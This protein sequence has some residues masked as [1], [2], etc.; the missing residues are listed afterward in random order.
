MKFLAEEVGGAVAANNIKGLSVSEFSMQSSLENFNVHSKPVARDFYWNVENSE[1]AVKLSDSLTLIPSNFIPTVYNINV[2]TST[3]AL[4]DVV[5][6]FWSLESIGIQP[7]QEK[8]APVTL[9]S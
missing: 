3:Q 1:P 8:K 4:D 2:D 7:I 9:N 5:R 6:E